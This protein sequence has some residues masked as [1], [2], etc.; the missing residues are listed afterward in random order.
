M[1][2]PFIALQKGEKDKSSAMQFPLLQDLV[3]LINNT[4][5]RRRPVPHQRQADRDCC[6]PPCSQEEHG[7]QQL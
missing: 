2:P 4:T 7:Y 1:Q 6:R 5:A 3:C